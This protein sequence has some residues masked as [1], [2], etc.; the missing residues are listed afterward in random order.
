LGRFLYASTWNATLIGTPKW[1]FKAVAVD[2]VVEV[3]LP[4]VDEV[5]D[6]LSIGEM[7]ELTGEIYTAR[8]AAHKRMVEALDKGESLPFDVRGEVIY[9][10]G[11]TPPKPGAIIGSAGPTTSGRMDAYT[12]R[13]LEAGL[14]GMI[15]KAGRS[16]PVVDA[17]AKHRAVYFAAVGGTAAL[18]ARS[19]KKVEMIAYEDLGTEAI[20][21]LWVERF[22]VVVAVDSRGND[23]FKEGYK[24]F[25]AE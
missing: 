23:I 22:P 2:G 15:G 16:R 25:A 8:D 13:I 1:S 17:I 24:K 18:L 20:R 3:E 19:I 12:P 14:K 11:P 9:Y 6:R 21:K 5:V 10:V 4:L 7:C